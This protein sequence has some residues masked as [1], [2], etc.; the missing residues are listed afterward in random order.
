MAT[1]HTTQEISDM[2]KIEL[3]DTYKEDP[4]FLEL[5][6]LYGKTAANFETFITT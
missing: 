3:K 6:V 2:R 4:L 1:A 5:L